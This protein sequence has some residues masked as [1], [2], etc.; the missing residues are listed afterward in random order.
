MVWDWCN[1]YTA[2][3]SQ[4]L[5]WADW[6]LVVAP[7]TE[8]LL[9]GP[10]VVSGGL[11]HVIVVIGWLASPFSEG[12]M[13]LCSP[14]IMW[15]SATNSGDNL[16]SCVRNTGGIFFVANPCFSSHHFLFHYSFFAW[17]Q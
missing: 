8:S 17:P 2:P 15:G 11:P 1:Q 4:Q 14:Q 6:G 9:F 13:G 12:K 3:H 10:Q 16:G 5:G 7:G